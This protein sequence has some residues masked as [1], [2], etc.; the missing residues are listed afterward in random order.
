MYIKFPL[1]SV[2]CIHTISHLWLFIASFA[3]NV[4]FK[5]PLHSFTDNKSLEHKLGKFGQNNIIIHRDFHNTLHYTHQ[6][7]RV[8]NYGGMGG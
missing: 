5:Y 8:I 6:V 1:V 4:N 3:Q 2:F 7:R